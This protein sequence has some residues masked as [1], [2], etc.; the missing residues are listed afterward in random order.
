MKKNYLT[1]LSALTILF[2]FTG[3]RFTLS[4]KKSSSATTIPTDV[5]SASGTDFTYDEGNTVYINLTDATSSID[6]STYTQITTVKTKYFDGTV[7][8]GFTTDDSSAST[9]LINL[10]LESITENFAVIIFGTSDTSKTGGIKIQT[11]GEDGAE[12]GIILSD[13]T[14]TSTNYPCIEITKGGTATVILK[15]TNTLTE[16]R[17]FGTGYGEQYSTTSGNTYT[18]DDVS[19]S[20]TVVSSAVQEGS[21]AKG[22]LFCKGSMTLCGD[23]SLTVNNGSYSGTIGLSSTPSVTETGYKNCIASKANLVIQSGTYNL[24]SAG[25]SGLYGDYC[26]QISG[27]T[28]NFAGVGEVS[29]GSGSQGGE[30]IGGN[31][32]GGNGGGGSSGSHGGRG[33]YSST[34][35]AVLR[36]AHGINVDDDS[37]TDSYILISGGTLNLSAYNG[38]GITAPVVTI[39]GGQTCVIS[40]GVTNYVSDNNISGTYTTADGESESG[41]IIF[42][43]EGIEAASSLEITGGTV[44]VSAVDD[45]MNVSTKTSGTVT[46]SDGQVYV[47]SKGGDGID[48]NGNIDV[49]GGVIVSYALTSSEDALD[50][51][52]NGCTL[53]INDALVAGL[54][55]STKDFS[56]KGQVVLS[57]TNISSLKNVA[58]QTSGT[59]VF[60]F[61][62]DSSSCGLFFISSPDFTSSCTVYTSAAFSGGTSFHG[63]YT[64][65]PSVTTTGTA[66]SSIN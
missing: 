47:Y 54:Q 56:P 62:P 25:K 42:A 61:T 41:N 19:Y 55:G 23:G 66:S 39:S 5:A 43:A 27:G 8:I 21:D 50:C 4:G 13:V 60:C 40:S 9:G 11:P 20:C 26:V 15:G 48:S 31:Q 46:I 64:T 33:S 63:L 22:T 14:M 65:L 1:F 16:G 12:V 36:K 32:P 57:G 58:V 38:K 53:T 24:I 17:T 30:S 51:G 3:C 49:S 37:Y 45:G 59:T 34:T 29:G 28:V 52:D 6:N 7:K 18:E 35:S 2:A 44:E 10:N